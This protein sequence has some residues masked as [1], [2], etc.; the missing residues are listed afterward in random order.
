[1]GSTVLHAGERKCVNTDT[2]ECKDLVWQ[3]YMFLLAGY[4]EGGYS[5]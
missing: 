3:V 4:C 2:H 5:C 1:M